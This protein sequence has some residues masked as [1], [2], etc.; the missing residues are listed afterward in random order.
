MDGPKDDRTKW[1]KSEKDKYHIIFLICRALKKKE[2]HKWTHLQNRTQSQIPKPR[3]DLGRALA[4]LPECR[5]RRAGLM[6]ATF[7]E[8]IRSLKRERDA[9]VSCRVH[10]PHSLN[11]SLWS[12]LIWDRVLF[13][14]VLFFS[15]KINIPSPNRTSISSAWS[16]WDLSHKAS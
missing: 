1:T 10:K 6:K 9:P 4:V 13:C 16:K 3:R 14:F 5:C 2:R 12:F 7:P 11:C 8:T 15:S